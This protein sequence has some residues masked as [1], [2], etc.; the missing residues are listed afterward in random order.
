MRAGDIKKFLTRVIAADSRNDLNPEENSINDNFLLNAFKAYKDGCPPSHIEALIEGFITTER[1]TVE[2]RV[3]TLRLV[4]SV[5]VTMAKPAV[6][7][8]ERKNL[9]GLLT[10]YFI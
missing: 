10:A 5:L 4:K 7:S 9:T 6:T 1:L 3:A 8:E 2:R